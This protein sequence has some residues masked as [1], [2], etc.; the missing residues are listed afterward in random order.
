MKVL[1][2][3]IAFRFVKP[4]MYINT[5]PNFLLKPDDSFSWPVLFLLPFITVLCKFDGISSD[6]KGK[7]KSNIH[8]ITDKQY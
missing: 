4:K 5:S 1:I 6:R 2:F 7:I 8:D 3:N